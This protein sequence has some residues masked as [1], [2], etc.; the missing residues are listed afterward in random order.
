M[1][2]VT[3]PRGILLD[4]EGDVQGDSVFPLDLV[5]GALEARGPVDVLRLEFAPAPDSLGWVLE[6]RV[7]IDIDMDST[8]GTT[9]AQNKALPNAAI[10]EFGSDILIHLD[11]VESGVVEAYRSD[12]PDEVYAVLATRVLPERVL[13]INL[14]KAM[15][16]VREDY[17]VAILVGSEFRE[18]DSFTGAIHAPRVP[19]AGSAAVAAV[20]MKRY[21]RRRRVE[22]HHSQSG[23]LLNGP[24][25]TRKRLVIKAYTPELFSPNNRS[26][27]TLG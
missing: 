20:A 11:G 22:T 25:A 3:E 16:E 10:E 27:A 15:L 8:T 21:L 12:A 19:E 5:L 17:R 7:D 14:D 13:E 4:P 2:A 9:P 6:G 24:V 26:V 1:G 23:A 18:Y